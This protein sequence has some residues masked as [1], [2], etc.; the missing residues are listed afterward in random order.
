[1]IFTE[2]DPRTLHKQ[3]TRMKKSL[4]LVREAV[5]DNPGITYHDLG[6]QLGYTN[7]KSVNYVV[8]AGIKRGLVFK[9]WRKDLQKFG[10]YPTLN[11]D[12]PTQ[13]V[14]VP[15][16][17]VNDFAAKLEQ[18]AKDYIWESNPQG[19]A[20]TAIKDFIGWVKGLSQ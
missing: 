8:A 14:R 5:K 6:S 17:S 10:I 18:K 16:T 15:E 9:Y 4:K 1:M 19:V 2:R 12:I 11:P 3:P 20:T 7:P 13:E